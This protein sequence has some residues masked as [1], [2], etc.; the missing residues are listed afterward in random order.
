MARS[1]N[2]YIGYRYQGE[3][4]VAMIAG[5]GIHVWAIVGYQRLG[6]SDVDIQAAFQYLTLAQIH[7]A[8]D[9]YEK[10]RDEIDKILE[11]NN[12]PPAEAERRQARFALL[13]RI[14]KS[15]AETLPG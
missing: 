14:M 6:M 13:A 15:E 10:H 11:Y 7:A 8:F 12:L 1:R 5:T 3:R 4:R 2:G 9:Y